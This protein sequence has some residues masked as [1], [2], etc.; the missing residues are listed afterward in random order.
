[1]AIGTCMALSAFDY[2][3]CWSTFESLFVESSRLQ[4]GRQNVIEQSIARAR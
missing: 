1:M 3:V 4:L 2:S